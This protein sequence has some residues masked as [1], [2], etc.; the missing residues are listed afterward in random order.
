MPGQAGFHVGQQAAAQE[1]AGGRLDGVAIGARVVPLPH[2][3]VEAR[4]A[5]CEGRARLRARD[6]DAHRQP[7]RR[8]LDEHR[9]VEVVGRLARHRAAG[10]LGRMDLEKVLDAHDTPVGLHESRVARRD[11]AHRPRRV[12]LVAI[13]ARLARGSAPGPRHLGG[14]GQEH[15]RIV[16]GIEIVAEAHGLRAREGIAIRILLGR[17]RPLERLQIGDEVDDLLGGE[18]AGG[19]PGRHHGVREEHAR[20]P[21]DLIQDTDRERWRSPIVDW[22][23]PA[24][25]AGQTSSPGTRWQATQGPLLRFKKSARP[26][27]ASP[28][29]PAGIVTRCTGGCRSRVVVGVRR[30]A[31]EIARRPAG[32]ADGPALSVGLGAKLAARLGQRA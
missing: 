19:S 25:P 22:S 8:A 21:D 23:G 12:G 13:R 15:R 28:S 31:L 7:V 26:L 11:A 30:V 16:R 32:V 1:L 20:I 29:I 3:P 6:V 24:L 4:L 5:P 9:H 10:R 14:L 2:A 27:R 17:R 18:H